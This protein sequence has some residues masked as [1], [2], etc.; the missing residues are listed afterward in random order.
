MDSTSPSKKRRGENLE[1]EE[2]LLDKK[3]IDIQEFGTVKASRKSEFWKNNY[4]ESIKSYIHQNPQNYY[5]VDVFNPQNPEAGYS[6]KQYHLYESA[7]SIDNRPFKISLTVTDTKHYLHGIQEAGWDHDEV[8]HVSYKKFH[9]FLRNADDTIKSREQIRQI[10]R[11]EHQKV[12]H[13]QRIRAVP[14]GLPKI[15]AQGISQQFFCTKIWIAPGNYIYT[16]QRQAETLKLPLKVCGNTRFE[17]DFENKISRLKSDLRLDDLGLYE[18]S[19]PLYKD[20]VLDDYWHKEEM[21]SG[22]IVHNDKLKVS[23]AKFNLYIFRKNIVGEDEALKNSKEMVNNEEQKIYLKK[24]YE[25]VLPHNTLAYLGSLYV[26]YER[27]FDGSTY[28][29]YLFGVMKF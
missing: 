29:E 28:K 20:W 6:Y 15:N 14:E 13:V 3:S 16:E 17:H 22:T 2:P 18:T 9:I 11:D 7:T 27:P 24:N 25:K 5:W 1:N 19:D 12:N 10:Y 21:I 4:D 8:N 23:S 26:S